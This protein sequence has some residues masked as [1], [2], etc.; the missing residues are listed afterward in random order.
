MRSDF[1]SG[2]LRTLRFERRTRELTQ[3]QLGDRLGMP[4]SQIAR[5]ERG[6]SDLRLSTLIDIAR[7]L[8]LEPMLVPKQL[9]PTVHSL[10]AEKSGAAPASLQPLRLVGNEPEDLDNEETG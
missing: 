1:S 3:K 4:Q 9:V 5:I 7:T 6:R 8:G 2:L 10:V